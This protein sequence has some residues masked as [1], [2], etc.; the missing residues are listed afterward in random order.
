MKH[1]LHTPDGVR[2]IYGVECKN[3]L[4]I[5]KQLTASMHLFGYHDIETPSFEFYNVFRKEI[6]SIPEQELYRF[7]DRDGNIVS[8]RPDITPSIARACAVLLEHEEM[9]TRLCYCGNTF[10]NHKSY[11][12]R[13][14]EITQLGAEL[15]G[16]ESIEAD[17]EMIAMMVEGLKSVNLKDFQ[18]RI[19]HV[20]YLESL[21]LA[22]G[23]SEEDLTA[24]RLLIR[25]QNYYGAIQKLREHGVSETAIAGFEKLDDLHGGYEILGMAAS[26]VSDPKAK[27]AIVRLLKIYSLLLQYGVESYVTFDLSM[28]SNYGYYSG[29]LFSAFTHG[30]GDAIIRGGRYDHLLEKFGKC[31][32]AIGYAVYVNELMNALKHQQISLSISQPILL[33]YSMELQSQA[34]TLAKELRAKG[35]AVQL[36]MSSNKEEL[37][38]KHVFEYGVRNQ[39]SKVYY[40]EAA[41][42]LVEITDGSE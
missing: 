8:L 29:I 18:I 42:K 14:H 20:D 37:D 25:N 28:S 17:A 2:D 38:Q 23:L 6:G 7:F 34:I 27:A 1:K 5:Q 26:Y 39:A 13:L 24:I 9:P 30:T 12:G 40:L 36:F 22:T 11:L 33:V 21:Y 32:A 41:G 16:D 31:S 4:E 35:R 15:I 10:A 3:K 19:G